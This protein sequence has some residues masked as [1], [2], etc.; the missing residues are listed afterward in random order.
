M[1]D[2]AIRETKPPQSDNRTIR[3]KYA[4]AVEMTRKSSQKQSAVSDAR[5]TRPSRNCTASWM[6]S[7]LILVNHAG[8]P[9]LSMTVTPFLRMSEH[10]SRGRGRKGLGCLCWWQ[11]PPGRDLRVLR[12]SIEYCCQIWPLP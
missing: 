10:N 8:T 5:A 3:I 6:G 11:N 7:R 4:N 12:F 1:K 9:C 2:N